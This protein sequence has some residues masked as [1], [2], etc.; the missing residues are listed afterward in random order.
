DQQLSLVE[1]TEAFL[2]SAL[3]RAEEKIEEDEREIE[4]LRAQARCRK[5][6]GWAKRSAMY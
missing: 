6:P 1:E 2:R 3:A 5:N 4:Y